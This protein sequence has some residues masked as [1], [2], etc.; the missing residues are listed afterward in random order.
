MERLKVVSRHLDGAAPTERCP[1]VHRKA[2][3]GAVQKAEE[4]AA[5]GLEQVAQLLEA[6]ESKIEEPD[7]QALLKHVP[8][9]LDRM[10][11]AETIQTLF[12]H[13]FQG[14]CLAG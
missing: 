2:T 10:T 1:V 9:P 6:L 13:S 8:G 4:E 14:R 11:V 3:S 5:P 7:R 12:E